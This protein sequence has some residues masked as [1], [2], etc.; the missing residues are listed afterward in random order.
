MM[1]KAII[2]EGVKVDFENNETLVRHY[3]EKTKQYVNYSVPLIIPKRPSPTF[4]IKTKFENDIMKLP[5]TEMELECEFLNCI[6]MRIKENKEP[7]GRMNYPIARFI[8]DRKSELMLDYDL[9]N[10]NDYDNKED[11]ILES[12][13][14]LIDYFFKIGRPKCIYVRDEETKMYL[15]D[16]LDK[17]K[18]KIRVRPTLKAID[19]F[20][21]S[22]MKII[23]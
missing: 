15:K 13:N 18:I 11:Y 6:P 23:M 2:Y 1:F 22:L 8:A 17:A 3:D 5:R 7:E 19:G 20:F 10:K 21:D 14:L 4:T 12:V 16:I 9:I